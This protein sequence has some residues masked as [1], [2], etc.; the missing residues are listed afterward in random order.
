MADAAARKESVSPERIMQ[1]GLGFTFAKT[2]LSAI[3]MDVFTEL[4]RR[5]GTLEDVRGRLGLHGR[6]ARD[7]LD[8]L[9]ALGFLQRTNG[10]YANTPETDGS[11]RH[12]AHE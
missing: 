9:V 11:P 7:F 5:P 8:A 12:R 6:A 4:S 3:E 2:L 1:V 10:V